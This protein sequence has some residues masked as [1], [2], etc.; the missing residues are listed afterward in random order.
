MHGVLSAWFDAV[1]VCGGMGSGAA[2]RALHGTDA[3]LSR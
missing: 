2:T 1:A 3:L